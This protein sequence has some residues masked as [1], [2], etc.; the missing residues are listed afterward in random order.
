MIPLKL[1]VETGEGK[2]A[3]ELESQ[4]EEIE[5]IKAQ[6]KHL[7]RVLLETIKA[8]DEKERRR[9]E[10][11]GIGIPTIAGDVSNLKDVVR[12]SMTF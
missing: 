8:M 12:E 2:L 1:P 5:N 6:L 4:R 9:F 11:S 3:F 10:N 7:A